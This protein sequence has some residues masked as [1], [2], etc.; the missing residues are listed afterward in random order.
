MRGIARLSSMAILTDCVSFWVNV[1]REYVMY[2][3]LG[4]TPWWWQPKGEGGGYS[5]RLTLASIVSPYFN[6][7][8]P[9]PLSKWSI[10]HI[11]R[12]HHGLAQITCR[13]LC[14]CGVRRVVLS[15][16]SPR[17]I[18]NLLKLHVCPYLCSPF[19]SHYWRSVSRRSLHPVS[20][21]SSRRRN[22]SW[23]RVGL[24][25]KSPI[26]V[27]RNILWHGDIPKWKESPRTLPVKG[28]S[29]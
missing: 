15:F 14:A 21:R 13:L 9:T 17:G 25:A 16:S 27:D 29:G 28:L 4:E 26:G 10:L 7:R 12:P 2:I 24:C 8:L 6:A 20:M 23:R 1:A 18:G 19:S 3:Y 22:R 5:S 11:Y